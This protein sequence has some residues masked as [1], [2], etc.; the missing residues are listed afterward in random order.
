VN[1][2]EHPDILSEIVFFS[3]VYGRQRLSC[4]FVMSSS[5]L[6]TDG[7]LDHETESV[8]AHFK[9]ADQICRA[10]VCY[11]FL[12]PDVTLASSVSAAADAPVRH[13]LCSE[14]VRC[15]VAVLKRVDLFVECV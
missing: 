8:T 3:T 13:R 14:F 1:D 11:A 4:H 9:M 12:M 5:N 15:I 6:E 2:Y 7:W 10:S